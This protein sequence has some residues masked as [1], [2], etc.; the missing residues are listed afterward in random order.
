M[1]AKNKENLQL[2]RDGKSVPSSVG[3]VALIAFGIAVI[4]L[5]FEFLNFI[6]ISRFSRQLVLVELS[7][8]KTISAQSV[9][10]NERSNAVIKQF[11][12]DTFVKMFNWNGV[13]QNYDKE[14]QI[15]TTP[16]PGVIIKI[17]NKPEKVT[18]GAYNAS[19]A[20]SDRQDFRASFLR[21]LAS[22]TPKEIFDAQMQAA[23]VPRF[24]SE[25]RKISSGRWEVDVV[26][27]LLTF[28]KGD[29]AGHGIPVNKTVTVEAIDTPQPE[30]AMTD[31]AKEIYTVRSSGLEITK[32]VDLDLNK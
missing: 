20:L 3:I 30:S 27:T 11:V 22:M 31:L 29:N 17:D 7:S 28:S 9:D 24:V 6:S 19:F 13:V 12:S 16:D 8:G 15:T 2:L 18:T 5:L 32:I 10:P 1:L 14:G 26:A 4:T 25:P 21:L 23:L